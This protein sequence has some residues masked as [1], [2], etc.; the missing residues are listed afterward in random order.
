MRNSLRILSPLFVA[1]ALT[2][3][4]DPSGLTGPEDSPALRTAAGISEY[5][6]VP[7]T[8]DGTASGIV[9]LSGYAVAW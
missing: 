1:G 7:P 3:C 4:G 5:H 8:S 6:P 9:P 2:A